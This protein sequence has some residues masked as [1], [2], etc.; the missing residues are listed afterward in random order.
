MFLKLKIIN[1]KAEN[2]FFHAFI[3]SKVGIGDKWSVYI[4]IADDVID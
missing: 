2:Q 3:L 1:K 4:A